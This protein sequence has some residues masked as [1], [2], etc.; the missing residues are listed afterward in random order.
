[1]IVLI[2]LG[3]V[4]SQNQSDVV[5]VDDP[6][7][8]TEKKV[9]SSIPRVKVSQ[10]RIPHGTF[11][12][13]CT[14]TECLPNEVPHRVSISKDFFMMESEVTQEL[15]AA[16]MRKNPSHHYRCGGLCPVENVPWNDAVEYANRL[17]I[18]HDYEPCYRQEGTRW[19]WNQECTGWRLP[20]ET[21]WEYAALG[22]RTDKGESAEVGV[23]VVPVAK[24]AWHLSDNELKQVPNKIG[25][26]DEKRAE[27]A[28]LLVQSHSV[29]QRPKNGYG[30]CDMSGNVWEWVWDGYEA[31]SGAKN[32]HATDPRG[33]DLSRSRILK[34]GS[35]ADVLS[36]VMPHRRAHLPPWA[37]NGV[38]SESPISIIEG[39]VGFRLVRT[40]Q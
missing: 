36:D 15:Y 13:G 39:T 12:M 1:M 5:Q 25:M 3:V 16:V 23:N 30:L 10:V 29:C 27:M 22:V 26:T 2:L 19:L 9:R 4:F 11:I 21:E 38:V 35:F 32:H 31:D 6:P 7:E 33:P 20:T 28:R 17:S 8:V 40:T 24:I 18:N 37:T 14:T 34:G